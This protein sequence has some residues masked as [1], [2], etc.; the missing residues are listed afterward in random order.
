MVWEAL[1]VTTPEAQ[2][3]VVPEEG[4]GDDRLPARLSIDALDILQLRPSGCI[5]TTLIIW[6]IVFTAKL[7]GFVV[8]CT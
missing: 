1:D 7:G 2:V 4:V 5:L 6:N 8:G 3:L